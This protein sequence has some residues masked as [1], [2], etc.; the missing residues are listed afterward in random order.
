MADF[1]VP[2]GMP[3]AIF[4]AKYSRKK[5]DGSFQTWAERAEEVVAGNCSLHPTGADDYERLLALTKKGV[6]AWAGR[7]LQQGDLQ[8]RDKQMEIFTNCS[9]A[10]ASFIKFWLLMKGSGVGRAYDSDVCRVDWS[11]MPN[12][13]FVLSSSHPDYE[14]WIESAEEA[15]HKY[16]DESEAVRWFTVDDSAE[17]WVK[18]VE[19]LETAA[20]QEKHRDKLFIF[21]FSNI[22]KCGAPIAGQQGR[23]ASGP[24]P[25]IRALTKVA[26]IKTAGMKPWKQA[27]HID[28]YLAECVVLGGVRRSARIA[29]K[30]WRDRDV[31]EFIDIKRGGWLYTANNSVTVDEEFWEQALNPAPSHGRRVYEAIIGASYHDGTGEPGF[32]DLSNMTW[33]NEGVENITADTILSHAMMQKMDVHHRTKGMLGKLL[34]HAKRKK[35]PF[36]VNPC[37]TAD[38]WIETSDGPQQVRDLVGKPFEA[39]VFGKL[40]SSTGFWSSGKKQVLEI[41]LKD[42]QVPLRCTYDH[43]VLVTDSTGVERKWVKAIELSPDVDHILYSEYPEYGFDKPVLVDH[44][45]LSCG[46]KEVFDCTVNDVHAYISNGM[47]SHNC[48]EIVLAIWG[49]YCVIGDICLANADTEEEITE[50]VQLLA[51]ALMRVNLMPSLYKAEVERTNRIGVCLTGI[52]E[53][54]AKAYG[55]NVLDVLDDPEHDL[56]FDLS[57][58]NDLAVESSQDYAELL[59]VNAPHT[60]TSIKPSGT[61]SKAMS[62]TEGAH[63]PAYDC[64]LRWVQYRHDS[65]ALEDLQNRGYPI[66]DISHAYPETVVVG[67]PTK[68]PI[69]DL[70]GDRVVL[71]GDMTLQQH[72]DWLML[73]ESDWLHNRGNNVSY[74]T[75]FRPEDVPYENYF[76]HVLEKQPKVRTC[77]VMPQVDMSAYAYQPEERISREEYDTLVS[78]IQRLESEAYDKNALECEGGACPIEFDIN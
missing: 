39:V 69:T 13:R 35:Y 66:K 47:Y 46:E 16:D 73:L 45:V 40:Y 29:T 56:R 21:D 23:P 19:V 75:K 60:V 48:G 11:F 26:S 1:V 63:A 68:M 8:Q 65:P 18:V 67:F 31:I 6:I 17:G 34:E 52:H 27:M 59:H 43:R 74:T 7:H 24:V 28:H 51:R 9:T 78:K 14:N 57:V 2:E 70:L 41:W 49:G 32:L 10:M 15:K 61:I 20:F 50:A 38:T 3:R 58:W 71:A 33:S 54:I 5:A 12:A 30:S 64:Y 53:W 37:V 42:V 76:K 25:L 72:Y 22:R 62:C 55:H 36:L 77:S 4:E 44:L